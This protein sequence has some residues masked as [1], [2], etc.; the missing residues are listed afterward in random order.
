[1]TCQEYIEQ[2]LNVDLDLT[3]EMLQYYA[4]LYNFDLAGEVNTQVNQRGLD[5]TIADLLEVFIGAGI[6]YSTEKK[7]EVSVSI[8]Y[9]FNQIQKR[10]NS[11]RAKYGIY[12]QGQEFTS[13]ICGNFN[14]DVWR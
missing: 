10:I 4:N 9:D 11:L 6:A 7:G 12:A 2:F 5:L 1:M 3:D 8:N 13:F 14:E